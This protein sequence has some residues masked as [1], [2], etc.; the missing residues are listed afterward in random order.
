MHNWNTREVTPVSGT[1]YWGLKGHQVLGAP[2]LA[3]A[4]HPNSVPLRQAF[5]I[6]CTLPPS[7]PTATHRAKAPTVGRRLSS[8]A[9]PVE[10]AHC[11]KGACRRVCRSCLCFHEKLGDWVPVLTVPSICVLLGKSFTPSGPQLSYPQN[12]GVTFQCCLRS[13]PELVFPQLSAVK[14]FS[15]GVRG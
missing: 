13:V 3:C 12:K 7:S 8:W 14:A 4:C 10:R 11:Q 5:C 1:A 6:E 2:P 9:V 15:S